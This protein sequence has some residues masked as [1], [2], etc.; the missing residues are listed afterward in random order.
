MKLLYV[1]RSNGVHDQRFVQAWETSNLQVNTL[2]TSGSVNDYKQISSTISSYKP[3]LIQVGPVTSPGALVRNLWTGPMIVTS[4]G[5]DLL[6]EVD[7]ETTYLND[8]KFALEKSDLIFTDNVAVTEKAICLGADPSA[9]VQFPWG[10]DDSWQ[11][12]HIHKYHLD[13]PTFISTR[14]HEELYRVEDIIRGFAA[15]SAWKKG[16]TLTIAG[17]GTLTTK[18][19][20]LSKKMGVSHAIE[21]VGKQSAEGL[22]KLLEKSDVYF[23]ASET[24]GSSISLLEAMSQGLCVVVSDIPGNAQWVSPQT[25]WNFEL[26]NIEQISNYFD[27]FSSLKPEEIPLILSKRQAAQ[28]LVKREANWDKIVSKFPEYALK[29]IR[30]NAKANN[31]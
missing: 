26:G 16:A 13:A 1:S 23:S 19:S 20:E 25:G 3:D 5:F 2:L 27:Y 4:W 11:D 7:E 30:N 21:L 9:I 15:S 17:S 12:L 8:A 31:R 29:A 24:D 14:N 22:H 10:L 6:K 28:S 18:I